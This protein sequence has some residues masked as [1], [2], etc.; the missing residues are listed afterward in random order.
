[1]V[2][3]YDPERQRTH[4]HAQH[5]I[6]GVESLCPTGVHWEWQGTGKA[7]RLTLQTWR[8]LSLHLRV[9][10]TPAKVGEES[11]LSG[12]ATG[13]ITVLWERGPGCPGPAMDSH[14]PLPWTSNVVYHCPP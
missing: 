9:E 6:V 11:Q 2:P 4:S 8:V 13:F 7:C 10:P 14:V 12:E 3:T 1:M 5:S